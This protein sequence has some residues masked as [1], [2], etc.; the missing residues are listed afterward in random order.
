[1]TQDH[2]S[3]RLRVLTDVSKNASFVSNIVASKAEKMGLKPAQK[4]LSSSI[5]TL[6][7]F[8]GL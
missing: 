6:S 4:T 5:T 2:S 8:V 1:M 7:F 3:K